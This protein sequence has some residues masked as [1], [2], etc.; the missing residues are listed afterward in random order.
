MKLHVWYCTF[1][2]YLFLIIYTA[3]SGCALV[4]TT[5]IPPG[6]LIAEDNIFLLHLCNSTSLPHSPYII[7]F[8]L[9]KCQLRPS[10]SNVGHVC[11][12]ALSHVVPD[13]NC[14]L[15]LELFSAYAHQR[16]MDFS[17]I[18]MLVQRIVR[19]EITSAHTIKRW[20]RRH[21]HSRMFWFRPSHH[22]SFATLAAC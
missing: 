6:K 2:F 8:L 18:Q 19:F 1:I 15:L 7:I 3:D 10:L 20:I 14:K 13:F 5:S 4:N 9:H 21:M 16:T 11:Q 22:H 17:M 12:R